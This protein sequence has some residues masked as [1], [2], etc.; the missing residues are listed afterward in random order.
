[1]AGGCRLR[2]TNMTTP[3][4][5]IVLI[6]LDSVG[7][8]ELPDAYRYGDA[9]ANTLGHIA[10]AAGPLALPHLERLGLGCI[11]RIR[12]VAPAARPAAYYGRMAE[13]SAGKD[14]LT[15]HWELMG[16]QLQTPFRAYPR[17]F[18]E[19]LVSALEAASGRAVIGN[20][21]A[22]GTEIIDELGPRHLQT[23]ELIVYTSA[24][25]VLQIAAH[26]EIVPLDELYAICAQ[27]RAMT[28]HEPYSVGRVIARPF[29]GTPGQFSRTANRRDFAVSPPQPT[30][31]SRLADAGFDS[32]GIGKISDIY[33]GE[34]ITRSV[35]TKS[36]REGVDRVIEE[37]QSDFHGL[38]FLNLVDF[39]AIYGHRRD[40]EGYAAALREFDERLPEVLGAMRP[41]DLLI[42][43]ADHGNDPTHHGT[44][45]TREYVPLLAIPY[46]ADGGKDLGVRATLADVGATVA[47]NFQVELPR[48]G[49][50][51]LRELAA[52]G[53]NRRPAGR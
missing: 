12:G 48:H 36:N 3:F 8:G 18:P 49:S 19:E 38:C 30:V 28:L 31:L 45:H 32:I 23:G 41:S 4:R 42:I 40:P 5:R 13:V 24:D 21:P 10:E 17:G 11:G 29:I 33:S 25:S 2:E 47:D 9:G 43:T 51:F 34:G 50:S 1:M 52:A 20:R 26:E 27:A 37:M 35:K 16:L 39:D 44:D 15:G 53:E 6:V 46:G 14:T 22:S 7:I